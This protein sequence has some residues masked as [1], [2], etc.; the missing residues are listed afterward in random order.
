MVVEVK[1]VK[2]LN[3]IFF[4][5]LFFFTRYLSSHAYFTQSSRNYAS[6]VHIFTKCVPFVYY[7]VLYIYLNKNIYI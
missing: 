6:C 2:I 1:G 4:R 3:K 7:F 5:K